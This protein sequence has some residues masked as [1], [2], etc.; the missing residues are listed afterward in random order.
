MKTK[1]NK[2]NVWGH[3]AQRRELQH[4]CGLLLQSI[5]R[6]RDF[7]CVNPGDVSHCLLYGRINPHTHSHTQHNP[8]CFSFC[9]IGSCLCLLK[10]SAQ[11]GE[12]S[13]LAQNTS[14]AISSRHYEMLKASCA[15]WPE[16]HICQGCCC[17]AIVR[18]V[19]MNRRLFFSFLW[20]K[21]I[22]S[23]SLN[24]FRPLNL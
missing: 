15:A 22:I 4:F 6:Q 2:K 1:Q 17:D 5:T 13:W 20:K 7:F 9:G 21:K 24:M 19:K 3:S 12:N 8:L 16:C 11:H 10:S 23:S 14:A 18:A